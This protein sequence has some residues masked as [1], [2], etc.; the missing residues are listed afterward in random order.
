MLG[1]NR[2]VRDLHD[3]FLSS[4]RLT[5][6]NTVHS[7]EESSENDGTFLSNYN[8]VFC[9][10]IISFNIS[11]EEIQSIWKKNHLRMMVRCLS[12]YNFI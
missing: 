5:R 11:Q 3:Q 9:Q 12:D 4:P 10:F 1:D 8:L 7:E 2:L 6:G